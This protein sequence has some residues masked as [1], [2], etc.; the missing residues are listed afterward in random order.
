MG[1]GNIIR[2]LKNRLFQ[3]IA[4]FMPGATSSRVWLHRGRGV[5][6]GKEVF[7]GTDVLIETAHPERVSIGNHVTI[8]IRTIIVAHFDVQEIGRRE[9]NVRHP[10]V[11]IED[12]VFIGPGVIVLPNVRIGR[13]AV[14]SAGSVVTHSVGP[15]IMVQGNPAKPVALCGIPLR[16]STDIWKFYRNLKKF[17]QGV[18]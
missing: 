13:G 2:G 9:G 7:I 18:D 3:S 11:N 15:R 16:R 6:I 5:K 1:E 4:R 17:D 14:I 8:G 10:T 12:E